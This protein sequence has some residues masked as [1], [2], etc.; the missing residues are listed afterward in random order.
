VKNIPVQAAVRF[1]AI[2]AIAVAAQSSTVRGGIIQPTA[3]LPP[4]AGVYTLP[5]LCIAPACISNIQV[6]GFHN[7]SDMV[8][9]GDEHVTS[10]ATFS[11][12]LFQNAGGSPGA[13]LGSLSAPGSLDFVFFGRT[14]ATPI[15]SF[16]SQ[17]TDFDFMGTFNGHQFE[18]KQN[19]AMPT[20]GVTTVTV[21]NPQPLFE[22]TSFFDV[23]AELS[24]D[25]GPFIPGPPRNTELTGVVPEPA[26]WPLVAGG[27][28]VMCAVALRRR[29]RK[30]A[31]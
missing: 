8:V 17:I 11:A 24:L 19:P 10:D 31:G 28:A 13:F 15:G 12:Q 3:A 27:A 18:A 26:T 29:G 1:S 6:S 30:T 25:G 21:V 23:F 2:A 9:G 14:L 16:H 4:P 22:I 20:T 5:D 7:T